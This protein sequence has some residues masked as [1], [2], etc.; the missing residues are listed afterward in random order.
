MFILV[1]FVYTPLMFITALIQYIGGR[2]IL[3][4]MSLTAPGY[5]PWFWFDFA[6]M[7]M[8]AAWAFF[9]TVIADLVK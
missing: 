2:I 5:W 1:A 9:T 6:L 8:Y 7:A 4:E 3:P